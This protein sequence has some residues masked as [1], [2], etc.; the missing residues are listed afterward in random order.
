[1]SAIGLISA[2]VVKVWF[3]IRHVGGWVNNILLIVRHVMPVLSSSSAPR[4][5]AEK[6]RA[7]LSHICGKQAKIFVQSIQICGFLAYLIK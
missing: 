5:S 7:F 3:C 1:M 2:I 4:D 6:Y